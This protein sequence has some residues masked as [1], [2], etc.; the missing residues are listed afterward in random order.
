M[1]DD[2]NWIKGATSEHPGAFSRKAKEQGMTSA[3]YAAQVTANP[4]KYDPKTVKQANLAKTLMKLRKKK[5]E[6]TK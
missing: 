4:D 5:E 1:S 2:K 3:E 6:G